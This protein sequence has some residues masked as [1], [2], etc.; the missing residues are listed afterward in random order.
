MDGR[1]W[2]RGRRLGR[3]EKYKS[4]IGKRQ[5]FSWKVPTGEDGGLEKKLF[6]GI[7]WRTTS[8]PKSVLLLFIFG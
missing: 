2:R 6:S 3:S 8:L 1:R 4:E 7:Q 5:N